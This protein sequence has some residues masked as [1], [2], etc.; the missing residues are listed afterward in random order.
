MTTITSIDIALARTERAIKLLLGLAPHAGQPLMMYSQ[1]GFHGYTVC[2][3]PEHVDYL[4]DINAVLLPDLPAFDADAISRWKLMN[5]LLLANGF[6]MTQPGTENLTSQFPALAALASFPTLEEIA[7]RISNRWDEDGKLTQSVPK[8]DG[9][10]TW[11]ADGT[12]E[13]KEYKA[14]HRIVA[15]SHKLQLMTLALDP[16]LQKTIAGLDGALRRPMIDGMDQPMSPLYERLQFFRDQWVHGR[17]FDGWEALLISLFLALVYFG[18]QHLR[19]H[20]VE[21][22]GQSEV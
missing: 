5:E 8:S 9:V 18:A 4:R 1:F 12:E 16:R 7:R 13:P 21:P 19:P 10:F 20:P 14:G 22:T 6:A 17:R 11:K 2:V 3:F 15:M